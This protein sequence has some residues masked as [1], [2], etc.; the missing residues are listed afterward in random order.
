MTEFPGTFSRSIEQK[1]SAEVR[2][3]IRS[4]DGR[5][6]VV[7][8]VR[9][10]NRR[11]EWQRRVVGIFLQGGMSVTLCFISE[12]QSRVPKMRGFWTQEIHARKIV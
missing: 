1:R 3:S 8:V 5:G 11:I 2:F 10:R 12:M 7:R 6:G 4:R 9:V